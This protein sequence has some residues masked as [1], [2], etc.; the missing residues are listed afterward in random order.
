V[1][2]FDICTIP[3]SAGFAKSADFISDLAQLNFSGHP[4]K[5]SFR[6]NFH[7]NPSKTQKFFEKKTKVL[8]C[9]IQNKD[10]PREKDA[11]DVDIRLFC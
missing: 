11:V 9:F 4:R 1:S 2:L 7:H 8:Q 3:H 10:F 5:E 6:R